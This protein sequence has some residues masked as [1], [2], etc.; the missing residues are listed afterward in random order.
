LVLTKAGHYK[1]T[2]GTAVDSCAMAD[3]PQ[4]LFLNGYNSTYNCQDL[5]PVPL[6]CFGYLCASIFVSRQL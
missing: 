5:M 1:R 3:S 6:G 4:L 2:A